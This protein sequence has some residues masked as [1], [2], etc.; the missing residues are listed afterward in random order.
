[1][2]RFVP[3]VL[4]ALLAAVP[5]L[6]GPQYSTNFNNSGQVNTTTPQSRSGSGPLP[7]S[8]GTGTFDG[9]AYSSFGYLTGSTRIDC[10]WES[11]FSGSF[12][13]STKAFASTDDILISGPGGSV[14]GTLHVLVSADFDGSGGFPDNGAGY[15]GTYWFYAG[16]AQ[17]SAYGQ[18]NWYKTTMNASG[19]LSGVN[20]RSF[21][22]DIPLEA[23]YP[24]NTPIFFQISLELDAGCYGNV[25]WNPGMSQSRGKVRFGS[26]GAF[27]DLPAGYSV[28][29]ASW[30]IQDNVVGVEGEPK[31]TALRLQVAGANPT[32]GESRLR[33]AL[34]GAARVRAEV[35][36]VSGRVVRSLSDDWMDAGIREL[37]WDGRD[38]GGVTVRAGLYFARVTA[39]GESVTTRV[40]RAR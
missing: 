35:F 11:G 32:S 20:S 8:N 39:G 3:A 26:N 40:V 17:A 14:H 16:S 36:D 27:M 37:R 23:N 28:N 38:A 21:N 6:A 15:S 13:S 4:I 29:S 2:H 10:L 22:I 30:G 7:W 9:H 25:G 19:W 31:V 1:M 34:P 18:V 33:L 5:A 24:V 12:G